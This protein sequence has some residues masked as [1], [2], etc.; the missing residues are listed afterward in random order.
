MDAPS[1]AGASRPLILHVTFDDRPYLLAEPVLIH[2][3]LRNVSDRPITFPY[4][5]SGGGPNGTITFR[6]RNAAGEQ[7]KRWNTAVACGGGTPTVTIQPGE[8]FVHTINLNWFYTIAK[9]GRYSVTAEYS[10]SGRILKV[11][12]SAPWGFVEKPAWAGTVTHRVGKLVVTAPTTVQDKAAL[13]ALLP[14]FGPKRSA[15]VGSTLLY[16][17][18][19]LDADTAKDFL[20]D[21]ARSRYADFVRMHLLGF[22]KPVASVAGAKARIKELEH[23]DPTRQSTLVRE[24]LLHQL[25]DAHFVAGAPA[26][27]QA[28]LVKQFRKQF[29]HSPYR[30]PDELDAVQND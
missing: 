8:Q 13:E 24:W 12:R 7:V 26:D 27:E 22:R 1:S 29:P 3:A 28:P 25:I 15:A 16:M 18:A 4:H 10:S 11:D 19:M 5:P 20:A 9:P 30:L 23:I 14:R 17:P 2:C 21:H 6:I